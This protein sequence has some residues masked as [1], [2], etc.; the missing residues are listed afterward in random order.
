MGSSEPKADGFD[1]R[2]WRRL[3]GS[4]AWPTV[5][6]LVAVLVLHV[7]SWWAC[8][9]LRWPLAFGVVLN[10]V[11]AYL[12]F[13]VHHEAAHGNIDG[14]KGSAGLADEV[15]GWISGVLLLSP[16][17]AVR[18]LH[19]RHHGVTN[20]PATDPDMWVAV[21]GPVRLAARCLTIIPHYYWHFLFGPT[22]TTKSA[23]IALPKTIAGIVGLLA[24]GGVL[25]WAGLGGWALWLWVLPAFLGTGFLAFAFDYLPHVP[26]DS[27]ERFL[28][29]RVIEGR[30]LNV[31][32]LGQNYHLMH[33]LYPR[34]P[35]YRYLA[36]FH[37]M[38]PLLERKG[39]RI[40]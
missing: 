31:V 30:T 40:D 35:F 21:D 18:V 7:G 32:L 26:F 28:N 24:L 39:A 20:D 22:S 6:L 29:T 17:P 27:R 8:V 15:A 3:T 16:F 14:R 10:A 25:W 11:V 1:E 19:L 38:R 4:F 37:L 23:R 13:T 2:A 12:A 36:C 5:A 34:V 9:V 33:H